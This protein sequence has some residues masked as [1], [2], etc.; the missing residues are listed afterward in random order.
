MGR[1]RWLVSVRGRVAVACAAAVA[2]LIYMVLFGVVD[3]GGPTAAEASPPPRGSG[4]LTAYWIAGAI[5]LVWLV[6]ASWAAIRLA[7]NDAVRF[8]D[9]PPS[10]QARRH[11]AGELLKHP[12]GT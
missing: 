9:L 10:E 7:R 12:E 4:N 11:E 6:L 1:L 3:R 8:R 5:I 2:W